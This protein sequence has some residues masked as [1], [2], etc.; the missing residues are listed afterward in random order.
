MQAKPSVKE[1]AAKE[2]EE[3]AT[4]KEENKVDGEAEVAAEGEAEEVVAQ[5]QAEAAENSAAK[6]KERAERAAELLAVCKD[7]KPSEY[8]DD[9]KDPNA[10]YYGGFQLTDEETIARMRGAAKELVLMAGKKILNGEFNLTRISFPIKCM[11]PKSILQTLSWSQSCMSVYLNHAA[12]LDDK[13]ERVKLLI[14]ATVA[15]SYHDKIFEKPLN[16][17][18]GETYE[19]YGQDGSSIVF[20]QTS[21]HPPRSNYIVEGPDMNYRGYGDLSFDIKS[22][23]YSASVNCVGSR[24]MHFKDGQKIEYGWISDY[25]WNIFM[26]TMSHQYTGKLQFRDDENGIVAT[27]DLGAYKMRA[28]DYLWGNIE[29]DGKKI[30]E[31][32]G[33][34]MGYLEF[35]KVR[36]WDRRD[37]KN[38]HFQPR[39]EDAHPRPLPSDSTLRTDGIY[40]KEKTIEEAQDEKERLENLQRHD[41]KLREECDK[42]R[43]N[44]GP[45]FAPKAT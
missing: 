1:E 41:R 35:D 9:V 2:A 29:K 33:N 28:Q 34:Y 37:Q 14:A 19:C 20:E 21:H 25:L 45:K 10:G 36:Y 30:C 42:R 17:I 5:T 23:P 7:W 6:E 16:P 26:G 32:T 11:C 39:V 8:K 24:T 13:V 44:G 31:I 38:I 12:S 3:A 27:F 22:N 15:S 4:L 18:L 43:A 40:L